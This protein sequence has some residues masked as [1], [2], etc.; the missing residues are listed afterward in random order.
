MVDLSINIPQGFLDE[1]VRCDYTVSSQ[2]KEVWAV[3]LDLLHQLDTVCKANNLVY[4]AGAGTLLGAI[5]HKGFIPWD[6]DIDIYMLRPDYDKLIKLANEFK[7]PY[8]LH[9]AYTNQNNIKT[10]A[11]LRNTHTTFISGWDAD[12]G[13]KDGVGIYIDIFPLDG[14]NENKFKN[15]IQK[16]ICH[17][18]R[19]LFT[20]PALYNPDWILIRKIYEPIKRVAFQTSGEKR[21]RSFKKYEALLKKYSVEGTKMWG[22]RTI[23]F[24][25]PK[26]RRPIEDWLDIV[27]IPF[28][29]TSIPAP[30]NYDEILRQQYKDYMVFPENRASGKW[31]R[32]IDISTD[33]IH[34]NNGVE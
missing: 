14:I 24:N 9:T 31:H 34:D 28:E 12:R 27:E 4:F 32:T 15:Q 30:R 18:Y 6:D 16:T 3:E 20:P 21:L 17:Y 7:E 33:Q 23:V 19:I 8:F 22:N 29:F 2:I 25:C 1:E 5:R 11:K 13:V 10:F 26:S